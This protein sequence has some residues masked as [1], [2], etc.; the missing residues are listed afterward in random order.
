MGAFGQ[1][2]AQPRGTHGIVGRRG[3]ADRREAERPRLDR[4]PF[5]QIRE[6]LSIG[7]K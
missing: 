4:Q 1:P 7:H 5:L 2:F 6:G 3:E